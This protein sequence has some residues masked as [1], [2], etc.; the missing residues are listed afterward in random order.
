MK[1][2]FLKRQHF[3]GLHS[4]VVTLAEELRKQGHEVHVEEAT[5]WIPNE[6]GGKTDKQVSE[7]LRAK[8]QDYDLVHA[9]GYR[10]GWACSAAYSHKEAWVYSAFDLPKTTHR[11]LITRLND[12][13]AGICS[14]R[15]VFRTLDEAIAIELTTIRPGVSIQTVALPDKTASRNALNLP[16][17][18]QVISV[19]CRWNQD[20]GIHALITSME[21]VWTHKPDTCLL[22]AGE[23]PEK[24]PLE[25]LIQLATRG[26][27]IRLLGKV[28]DMQT[29]F[30]ASDFVVVPNTRKGFSMTA[31]EA[32]SWG[33][34][35]LARNRH[36]LS[37]LFDREIS[38]FYFENDDDLARTI[39]DLLDMPLTLDSVGRAGKIRAMDRYSL[40]QSAHQIVELYKSVLRDIE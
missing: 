35:V 11:Q 25:Q 29:L 20:S 33:V 24:G 28:D 39:V 6:T 3:G 32:M 19:A 23:G 17:E 21:E 31:V 37:E 2:Y 10:A 22:I 15:A 4:H 34:P 14:S 30:A 7:Q 16:L 1:L 5:E 36:G 12:S 9:F 8:T 38:G 27:Q 18:T 13:Q 26:G 40:E